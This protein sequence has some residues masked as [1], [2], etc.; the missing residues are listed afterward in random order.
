[1]TVSPGL[2]VILDPRWEHC[3]LTCKSKGV[4]TLR[5]PD[6]FWLLVL[7]DFFLS[8]LFNSHFRNKILT[9]QTH[10]IHAAAWLSL[11]YDFFLVNFSILSLTSGSAGIQ[12]RT[13][14]QRGKRWWGEGWNSTA[15]FGT[16]II[17]SHLNSRCNVYDPINTTR[18][19]VC[20]PKC[21]GGWFHLNLKT[22]I[23]FYCWK[24]Y[25][26]HFKR[27]IHKHIHTHEK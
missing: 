5:I 12:G 27:Q 7:F 24:S 26:Q 18:E 16:E 25:S 22:L 15:A 13:R 4:A 9:L 14:S 10:I 6:W 3:V 11:W 19:K 1:M 8:V 21:V 2:L 23:Q 20:T 17:Q